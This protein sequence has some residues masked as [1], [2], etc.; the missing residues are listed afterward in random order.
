ML[1]KIFINPFFVFPFIACLIFWPFTLQLLSLK[2]DALTYYYPIRTLIS[3]AL[4]NGEFP[5]WTP[6]INLG[7]PLHADMQS[8]AWNPVIWIFSYISNYSLAAFHYELL[9]YISF[10]GIGFYF[11]CRELGCTVPVAFTM[12]IAYQFS[13]FM[14]DSV[15]FFTC[16]SG[17]CYIPYIFLFFRRMLNQH[18]MKDA[19][20]LA[21]FLFLLFTG[22]YPSLFII[23]SYTLLAYGLFIFFKTEH[24]IIFIKKAL[25]QTGMACILFLLLSLPAII[26]FLQ[27]LPEIERGKSQTL[28]TVL[29]NSMNP[30]S[31]LSLITPFGTTANDGWLHSSILM[32]NIYF[33]IIPLIFLMFS[34]F[35]KE[36]KKNKELIFFFIC[37]VVMLGLAWGKFFF[38]R[39]L[40]YYTLPLMNSFRHPA[41][42][43]LF[44]IFFFLM[45]SAVSFNIWAEKNEKN[46]ALL[47][48]TC[49]ILLTLA[50]TIGILCIPF[51]K[52]FLPGKEWNI[53]GLKNLLMNLHFQE[54]YLVQLPFII[55]IILCSCFAIVKKKSPGLIVLVMIA[56]MF[57][58][59]QLNMP[60]TVYGSKSFTM[61]E[62]LI[63]R[64][65]VKF[66]LPDCTSIFVNS[67][68]SVD[69]DF[70]AG[71]RL[72]FSKKIGR[73][74]YYITP[75]NLSRQDEFYESAIKDSIFK[76]PVL[77]FAGKDSGSIKLK[78]FSANQLV[79]DVNNSKPENLVYLQNNY[80]GWLAF[81]DGIPTKITTVNI[82]FMSIP[83][84]EGNHTIRFK[85][86]PAM[87]VNAWY[88]SMISL[89]ILMAIYLFLFFSRQQTVKH[90]QENE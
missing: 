50:L 79:A 72:P 12:A 40:A 87:I 36:L 84:P 83:V 16:I 3:D 67:L 5:L 78:Y 10:A 13:G 64:N 59:T 86:R 63:N 34:F 9:F 62:K 38:F 31:M 42:F 57:L 70:V 53:N 90:Q 32:R 28:E 19:L 29:E 4:N 88:I 43:R 58:A 68:N 20:M 56:D 80:H 47:K 48:K 77:Y 30:A 6:Y 65:P 74:D 26:S 46:N 35:Q 15:Q 75:G 54:R 21:L 11:L 45:I 51:L 76:N 41:L 81:V 8:G 49:I 69:K 25:P 24:K 73:N 22:G 33:G 18:Q 2:N 37:A 60:I 44:S 7:Y 14:T 52:D 39:Q 89:V 85:Y 82:S 66:P 61:I 17:A 55:G 23:L 1:R 27:H 71:S